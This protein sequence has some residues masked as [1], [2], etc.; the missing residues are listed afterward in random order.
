MRVGR[1]VLIGVLGDAVAGGP[2]VI[3]G[4]PEVIVDADEAA[5][6]SVNKGREPARPRPGAVARDARV[7]GAA[8]LLAV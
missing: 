3:D 2:D 5:R 6:V 8:L 1:E 7:E 4:C